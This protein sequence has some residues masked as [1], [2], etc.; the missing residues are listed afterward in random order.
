THTSGTSAAPK[1][2]ER[3]VGLG[4][5]VSLVGLIDRVPLRRS[6]RML[7]TAP[8]FHAFAQG[9]LGAAVVLGVGMVLPRR[10]DADTFE[11]LVHRER[12]TVAGLVPVMLRRILETPAWDSPSP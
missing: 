1:G 10:F 9:L 6:D 3:Q 12:C 5:I 4:G 8:L 11:P 2:A 7:I